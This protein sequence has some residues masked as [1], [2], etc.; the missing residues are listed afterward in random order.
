M[1]I[2]PV[3]DG[4]ETLGFPLIFRLEGGFAYRYDFSYV[5]LFADIVLAFAVAFGVGYACARVYRKDSSHLET[6]SLGSLAHMRRGIVFLVLWLVIASVL[7][8][9][10]V[11]SIPPGGVDWPYYLFVA[12]IPIGAL[13]YARFR[14]RTLVVVSYALIAGASFAL[15][16]FDD[17]RMVFAGARSVG[18]ITI[19][20]SFFA[21][22]MLI[23]CS[24]TFA[25]GRRIFERDEIHAV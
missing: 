3:Y 19:N 7:S 13:F 20:V 4:Y 10:F 25:L 12:S 8:G 2:H 6:G 18:S 17:R 24:G 5:A 11:L 14:G 15:P 16:I 1:R 9:V 22:A 23:V 21:L